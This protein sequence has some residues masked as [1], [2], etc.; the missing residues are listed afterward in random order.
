[1]IIITCILWGV[2]HKILGL[3]FDTFVLHKILE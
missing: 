1:L 2:A 3:L